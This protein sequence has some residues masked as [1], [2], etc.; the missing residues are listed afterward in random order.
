VADRLLG[1]GCYYV[2]NFR[3][4]EVLIKMTDKMAPRDKFVTL[5]I[6]GKKFSIDCPTREGWSTKC[7]NLVEPGGLIFFT[8]WISL[9]GE[10]YYRM[11]CYPELY[12]SA[13]ILFR[14]WLCLKEFD[15]C[16]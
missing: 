3:L 9:R 1:N 14:N 15:W 10:S 6:F 12:Y 8:G 7:V 4:S 2:P 16:G 11:P 13:E 5:N